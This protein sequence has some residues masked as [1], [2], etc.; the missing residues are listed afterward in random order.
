MVWVCV[1]SAGDSHV[2]LALWR[3]WPLLKSCTAFFAEHRSRLVLGL[4][5]RRKVEVHAAVRGVL[6]DGR[7]AFNEQA[8]HYLLLLSHLRVHCVIV[9]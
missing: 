1:V 2:L 7:L 5:M 4:F 6:R 3:E 8:M 9:A